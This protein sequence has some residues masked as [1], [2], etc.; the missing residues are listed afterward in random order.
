[1]S[2]IH[3]RT[4]KKIS[5]TDTAVIGTGSGSGYVV[6]KIGTYFEYFEVF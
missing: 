4:F 6:I 2:N 1:M 3:K 5:V